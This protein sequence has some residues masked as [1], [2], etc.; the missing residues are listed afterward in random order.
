MLFE[1]SYKEAG[2]LKST[3]EVLKVYPELAPYH[4]SSKM[5]MDVD[6]SKYLQIFADIL[7]IEDL[8]SLSHLCKR[9]ISIEIHA[10]AD[11]I[12]YMEFCN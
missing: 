11:G 10:G 8:T 9:C 5:Y 7:K 3:E 12:P 6:G 1:I 2:K 4:V